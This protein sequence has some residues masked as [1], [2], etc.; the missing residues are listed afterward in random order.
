M[1]T[2]HSITSHNRA[3]DERER[4]NTLPMH[5]SDGQ[6]RLPGP[7][8]PMSHKIHVCHAPERKPRH[9][10]TLDSD[11]NKLLSDFA[12]SIEKSQC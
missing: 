10:N 2:D 5:E 9:T 3:T 8:C 1:A 11:G 12:F 4:T 7:K 6:Q